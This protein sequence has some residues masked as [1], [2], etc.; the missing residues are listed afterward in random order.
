[1]P[2]DFGTDRLRPKVDEVLQPSP[3]NRPI[4]R[5]RERIEPLPQLLN[6]LAR[7][8][9]ECTVLSDFGRHVIEIASAL[10]REDDA[11]QARAMRR[12]DLAKVPGIAETLDWA[13]ALLGFGVNDLGDNPQ[14]V[15]D[16]LACLLKTRE[17]RARIDPAVVQRL[18]EKVGS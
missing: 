5:R 9:L 4:Q 1:M 13:R 15:F 12:E 10:A 2:P 16:S 17:D 18:V 8:S 14:A 11:L 3:T 6:L 7:A